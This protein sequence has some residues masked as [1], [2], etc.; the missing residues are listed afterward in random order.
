MNAISL[1]SNCGA[2]DIGFTA[3]GFEFQVISELVGKRL[4]VA[5][6]NHPRAVSVAGDL[7]STWPKVVDAFRGAHGSDDPVLLSGCPPCQGMSSAR[8]GRGKEDDPDASA[9]DERNLL[10][11][12]IAYAAKE[13]KPM[14]VVV[15]NVPA[16]LR[17]KVWDPKGGPPVSAARILCE[18][19]EP[20]YRVYAAVVDLCEFGVPQTRLRAFLVFVKRGSAALETLE[21]TGRA[22]IPAP[23]HGL[24]ELPNVVSLGRAL[25]GL[26]LPELDAGSPETAVSDS[27]DLHRVPVWGDRR[28]NMVAAI[29]PGSGLS[30][31][32]NDRCAQCGETGIVATAAVCPQCEEPLLRPITKS[33]EGMWRLVRGFRNSSYRRMDPRRPAATVTTASGH[34]G[35]DRNIHPWENRVLSPAECAFLQTFPSDFRWG[36]SMERWGHTGVRQMIGEAVPPRFTRLHGHVLAALADGRDA[37]ASL[38][39]DD[40]RCQR[41]LAKLGFPRGS[42]SGIFSAIDR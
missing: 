4:E 34:I 13:L 24:P 9:R 10:V 42:A 1:F 3:A 37:P 26:A 11:L 31:W 6:L 35:S 2:G 40:V 41:A 25:D 15:E 18:R 22:P 8:G 7:R 16:F 36:D 23:T 5:M 12:P 29:R 27:D 21:K 19:L 38:S 39:E 32:D 20:D 17:R 28:Y 30:A 33:R 14:F